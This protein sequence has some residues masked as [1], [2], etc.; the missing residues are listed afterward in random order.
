LGPLIFKNRF[1][2]NILGQH[3]NQKIGHL[4]LSLAFFNINALDFAW[5]T[6]LITKAPNHANLTS[7][8]LNWH[9]IGLMVSPFMAIPRTTTTKGVLVC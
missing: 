8:V 2:K 3:P 9:G 7:M 1:H 6:V 5:A 4:F